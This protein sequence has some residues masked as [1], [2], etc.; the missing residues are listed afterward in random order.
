LGTIIMGENH[1]ASSIDWMN[2]SVN[3]LSIF[4]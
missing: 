4:Q 2:P 3:N 1:V